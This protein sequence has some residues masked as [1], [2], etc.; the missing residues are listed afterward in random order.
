MVKVAL[1]NLPSSSVRR[2]EEHNGLAFL[3][4][5]L[6]S[7]NVY[8]KIFDAYAVGA[9]LERLIF[10]LS[11]WC[12]KNHNSD[13]ILAISPYVTSYSSLLKLG[14]EMKN[15]F[16]NIKIILG[17][18]F[19]SLHREKFMKELKWLDGIIL[20]EGELTILDLV[21]KSSWENIPGFYKKEENF[22]KRNRIIELDDLP[23]QTRYLSKEDLQNQ[24]YSLVTSRGCSGNCSFCSMMSFY[25]L[26]K[27]PIQSSRSAKNVV[28]EMKKIIE[29]YNNLAFKIVDDNFFRVNDEENKFLKDLKCE[30]TKENI[31]PLIRLSARP[32]DITEERAKLLKDIGVQVLA[33]GGESSI[34]KSLDLFN[35]K[36]TVEI[37]ERTISILKKEGIKVL[38]NFIFFDPTLTIEDLKKNHTFI[39]KHYKDVILHRINSHLW[40]RNTDQIVEKLSELGLVEKIDF[41]Y[42]TYKYLDQKVEKI[43][44]LF[45]EYCNG[46]MKAYY[47]IVDP[48]M[49]PD[50]T[51]SETHWKIYKKFVLDDLNILEK[52]ILNVEKGVSDDDNF[53]G[54]ENRISDQYMLV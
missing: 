29:T 43:K 37:T 51:I 48:L 12:L 36:I 4:S 49:A 2:G 41:P 44:I 54:N 28:D 17:G 23:F 42:V 47:T 20:G 40:L 7:N 35:K 39:K 9:T 38:L 30:L 11:E 18:H 31:A 26:N 52:I 34:Q 32:D 46:N 16:S 50:S 53:K 8:S 5:F 13:L 25:S 24:P 21:S 15:K 6:K 22:I 3:D 14:K 1:I 33:I 45:D 27:G 10:E 19:A